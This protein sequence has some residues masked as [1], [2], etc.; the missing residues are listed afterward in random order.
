M[1][2]SLLANASPDAARCFCWFD[3]LH[4]L[5]MILPP[6]G[7]CARSARGYLVHPVFAACCCGSNLQG[8]NGKMSASDTNSAI[9]VNDTPAQIKTKVSLVA[10]KK[11]GNRQWGISGLG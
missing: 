3:F 10:P 1:S 6:L 5:K 2:V 9:F 4:A 7:T 8:E 11:V